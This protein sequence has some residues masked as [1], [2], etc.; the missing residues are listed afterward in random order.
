MNR[1]LSLLLVVMVSASAVLPLRARTQEAKTA[2]LTDA[3]ELEAFFD[4]IFAEQM[5]KLHIPGAAITV[6]KDGKIFFTK[7]YGYADLE[8]KTP[9]APDRTIFR[10]GSITKVFTAT[11]MVQLAERRKIDLHD[12]VNKYLKDFN[13][14][15]TYPQ[16]VTFTNLLTHTAGFDEISLGRKTTSPDK[17]IPLGEFLKTRLIR[18]RPPGELTSYSTYGISLMGY[19]VETISGTPFKQYLDKNIFKPLGM[20]RTSIGAVPVNLQPD[21]AIGYEYSGGAY[22][23]LGFEYFHTYPASDINSTVTDMAHFMNAHLGN[24]RYGGARILSERAA[25]EMH[26]RQFTNDPRLIGFTYGFFEKRRNGVRAAEHGGMMDGFSDLMY[27]LLDEKVGIYVACN[28]ETSG[29]QDRVKDEFLDRYFPAKERPK[30]AEPTP[31]LREHLD[32]FT[33]KYRLDNYCHTCAEGE[34][35][36]FPQAFDIT[37]N[38]DGTISFWGGRWRQVEPLLFRLVSGQLDT[39][40]VIVLFREDQNGQIKYMLNGTGVSEKLP[41][42]SQPI[43]IALDPKIYQAYVGQYEIAPDRLMTITREGDKLF[44]E[45]TG[46]PKVELFPASETRFIVKIADAEINFVKNA[47]GQ[48]THLLL[49]LNG[50]EM[51]A[52][53]IR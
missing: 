38:D 17:V 42:A 6:V 5:E 34:R 45:M 11:A 46:Q 3:K 48:I 28:R 14:P 21:L 24:G 13:V 23:P 52:K 30:V 40:E 9:V 22:R 47:Q 10:V 37:A 27:L 53:K 35:G 32:H 4:P 16:P 26:R 2:S 7:G 12:N 31:Q 36:Y 50:K 51:R 25:Q 18:R 43:I 44:G 33:G 20:S 19:L 29:L 8:K 49:F 1:I 15:N 41:E 39:G